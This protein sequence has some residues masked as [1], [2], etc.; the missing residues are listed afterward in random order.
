MLMFRTTPPDTRY[1]HIFSGKQRTFEFQFQGTFTVLPTSTVYLGVSFPNPVSMGIVQRAVV[2]AGLSWVKKVNKGFHYNLDGSNGENPHVAFPLQYAVDR[3]VVSGEGGKLPELGKAVQE[4]DDKVKARK[5][6]ALGSFDGFEKDKIYTL[7][8]WSSYVDW[9]K[10]RIVNLPGVRPF[11]MGGVSGNQPLTLTVYELES[12]K[13]K[14]EKGGDPG[15]E[16][17]Y[18]RKDD[19]RVYCKVEISNVGVTRGGV[20]EEWVKNNDIDG[21]GTEAGGGEMGDTSDSSD[22]DDDGGDDDEEVG[23]FVRSGE[24]VALREAVQDKG[25]GQPCVIDGGGFAVLQNGRPTEGVSFVKVGG[26]GRKGKGQRRLRDGDVVMV[27]LRVKGEEGSGFKYLSTHRGWWLKWV[28]NPPKHNGYFKVVMGE[29]GEEVGKEEEDE[30]MSVGRGFRL[31]HQRWKDYGVGVGGESNA[32][33][34][35]R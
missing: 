4:D 20:G 8:L 33:Y 2:G 10:W 7:C 28:T 14:V 18:H 9:V 26:E 34:G 27:R 12:E 31:R 22:E 24:A 23:L 25:K 30:F 5:K 13:A 29:R 15:G 19:M 17:K 3:L 21:G 6:G 11:G 1:A 16:P 32:K 35:G